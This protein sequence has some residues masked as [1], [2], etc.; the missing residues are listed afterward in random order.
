MFDLDET[1]FAF[2]FEE[3]L[4]MDLSIKEEEVG[5]M[6]EEERRRKEMS[7]MKERRRWRGGEYV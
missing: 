6:K 1:N 7:A 4:A 5:G 3:A 2:Q